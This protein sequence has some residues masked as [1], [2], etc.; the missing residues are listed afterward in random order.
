MAVDQERLDEFLGRF[1][2]DLGATIAAG[3]VVVGHRLGLYRALARGPATP[4]ELA[5]RTRTHPRYVAEWCRAQAAG[6]YTE[7]DP[8]TGAFALTEEQAF[9]LSDPDGP[10]YR[11]GAFVLA[12]AALRAESQ[13]TDAFRTGAGMG[14]HEHHEDVPVGTDMFFR[15]GYVAN[16]VSS[17]I[18]A[19][20]GVAATLAAGARIA[21][22]GCG[23]GA[24][25]VLLAQAYPKSRVA[26]SDYHAASIELAR[27]RAADA[28]VADR[29]TFEVATAQ[30]FPGTGY[31]L[32]ATFDCL[33]DMGDPVAAARHVREALAPD[34][35]WL[36][37]EPFAGDTV[38]ANLNPVGRVYYGFSTYL[39]VPNALS[40]D[41]GHALGA[42]AGEAA[43]REVVTAAGFTRF[44][45]AAET[46][47][48]LVL[49]ARP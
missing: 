24:S 14:W 49:E 21:D 12:L 18:P 1:V 9:A 17:W 16:L 4:D 45:R 5:A 20:D 6:G 35:T 23:L 33:H 11:P 30:D 7:Y 13:I 19:L 48:N 3:G 47:F 27:E 43:I 31:D 25:S 39:C 22:V 15:P 8:A 29:T 26:G 34:G 38:A 32:V 40:Q 41:G 36:V 46:P 37:V 28:G 42:Q 10:L 44:R 2:G